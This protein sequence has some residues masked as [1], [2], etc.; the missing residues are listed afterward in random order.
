VKRGAKGT[1]KDPMLA[2]M[3]NAELLGPVEPH[4]RDDR[5]GLW[6]GHPRGFPLVQVMSNSED[7]S[8]KVLRIANGMW[9]QDAREHY[10]LDPGETRTIIKGTGRP[11]RGPDRRGGVI[12]GRP[13]D[14]RRDQRVAPHDTAEW[15]QRERR[16]DPAQ[17][18][19]VAGE[20]PGSGA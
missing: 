9:T 17:R 7:Q 5:T 16:G 1:G 2:A 18:G 4:D 6:V 11:L 19:E 3:C 13:G 20:R 12:R 14:L 8:K 10:D 15:R